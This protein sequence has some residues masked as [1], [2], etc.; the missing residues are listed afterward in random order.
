[1][2]LFDMTSTTVKVGQVPEQLAQPQANQL[3]DKK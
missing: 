2:T 1:M 3:I